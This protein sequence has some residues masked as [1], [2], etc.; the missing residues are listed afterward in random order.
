MLT[1]AVPFAHHRHQLGNI[2]RLHKNTD[3]EILYRQVTVQE[4]G[5]RTK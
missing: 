3:K 1:K 5:W 2:H 4:F